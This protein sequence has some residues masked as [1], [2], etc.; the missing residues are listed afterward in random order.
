M[1]AQGYPRRSSYEHQW[2]LFLL[3]V[4]SAPNLD[5]VFEHKQAVTELP[6]GFTSQVHLHFIKVSI[7]LSQNFFLLDSLSS[8]L[9]KVKKEDG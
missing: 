4:I 9:E 1:T 3:S 6:F 8:F 7:L 5:R 2:P